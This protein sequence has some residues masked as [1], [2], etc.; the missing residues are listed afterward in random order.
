MTQCD[1]D[2]QRVAQPR[3]PSRFRRW[4]CQQRWRRLLAVALPAFVYAETGSGRS[5]A[6]IVVV[7]LMIGIGLGSYGGSLADRWDLRRAVV[8]TNVLQAIALLPL[9]AVTEDRLWP[10]FVVAALQGCFKR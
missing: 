10:A 5:T 3:L 7:E 9:L 8:A 6:A 4:A 1:N 2:R